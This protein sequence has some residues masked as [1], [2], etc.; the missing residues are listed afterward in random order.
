MF[1]EKVMKKILIPVSTKYI[2]EMRQAEKMG[3]DELYNELKNSLSKFDTGDTKL[4]GT[5]IFV[6]PGCPHNVRDGIHC[7][8]S[9]CDW[10]D[11]YLAN[12]AKAKVLRMKSPE[13][14]K[15]LQ[16]E[17]LQKLR[18]ESSSPKFM[19]EYAI[20]DCFDDNEVSIEE[21]DYIF[22]NKK[23]YNKMP[24]IGLVQVRADSVTIEKTKYWKQFA[25][26]QLTLGIGVETGDEW[27]RNHWLNKD[28]LDEKL[29]E[30]ICIAHQCGCK[31]CANLLLSLPGLT[32]KQCVSLFINSAE[33]LIK[34][35]CDS[36]MISPLVRK[37]FTL[38]NLIYE[39]KKKNGDIENTTSIYQILEVLNQLRNREEILER[40]MF[41]SLNFEDYFAENIGEDLEKIE[42]A[43]NLKKMLDIG[44]MKNYDSLF[45]EIDRIRNSESFKRFKLIYDKQDGIEEIDSTVTKLAKMIA[46]NIF[47]KPYS[48]EVIDEFK[49]EL[50]E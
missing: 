25:R 13:L 46:V 34:L 24:V 37:K 21:L 1:I 30:A 2:N 36:I 28:M 12:P 17:S 5:T 45:N 49:T 11:S 32:D 20:H 14:Y 40:L 10:N 39:I 33:K 15:K 38:Q 42:V 43:K 48:T 18:G 4:H 44:A 7:G 3:V 50:E 35:G 8:C 23:I 19:E 6:S 29:E 31:V 41:S 16:Y 26:K 47:D 27:L 22:K 9:F